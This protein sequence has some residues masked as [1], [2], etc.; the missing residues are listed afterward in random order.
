MT[1]SHSW[2]YTTWPDPDSA[3]AAAKRL[4]EE[5]LCVCANVFRGMISVY[6][7]Q[8]KVETAQEAVMV[9]KTRTDL[10]PALCERIVALHPYDEP[11]VLSLPVDKA[12]S[13]A[14]FLDWIDRETRP[15]S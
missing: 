3:E 2:T 12:G 6:R 13:A 15:S 4:I 5:K 11:C 8:G 1:M 14:G 9:L 7:W 10:A